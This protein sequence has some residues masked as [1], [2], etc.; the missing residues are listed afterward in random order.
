M[1]FPKTKEIKLKVNSDYPLELCAK[2][3]ASRNNHKDA[4]TNY[5]FLVFYTAPDSLKIQ[6]KL[7]KSL[8]TPLREIV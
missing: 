1:K 5:Q 7:F 2:L 6:K 8:N 4:W 3:L